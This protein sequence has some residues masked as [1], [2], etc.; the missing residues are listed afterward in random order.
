MEGSANAV[1][2]MGLRIEGFVLRR[3]TPEKELNDASA[4]W[5]S[6]PD[7]GAQQVGKSES[8]QPQAPDAE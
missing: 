3:P 8:S 2:S 4:A 6:G 5:L 1:W 7:L